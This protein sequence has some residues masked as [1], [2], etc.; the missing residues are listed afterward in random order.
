MPIS[1]RTCAMA[2]ILDAILITSCSGGPSPTS[3]SRHI[4]PRSETSD[5]IR[6]SVH[7]L[8]KIGYPGQELIMSFSNGGVNR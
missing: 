1:R 2:S 8:V 4:R 3:A 5:G 6:D 7:E